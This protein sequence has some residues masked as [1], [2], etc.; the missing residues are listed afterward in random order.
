M[1]HT[2]MV[3]PKAEMNLRAFMPS[4][5]PIPLLDVSEDKAGWSPREARPGNDNPKAS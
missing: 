4:T 1:N 2:Q 3:K 5:I